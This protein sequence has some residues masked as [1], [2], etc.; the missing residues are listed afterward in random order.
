MR[1]AETG[2]KRLAVVMRNA[3]DESGAERGIE[4]LIVAGG[5]EQAEGRVVAK[6]VIYG[7]T[8]INAP[9]IFCIK[10]E[11]LNILRKA[12]IARGFGKRCHWRSR[13]GIARD[14]S[15]NRWDPEEK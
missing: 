15:D 7:E 9:G 1:D 11:A 12:A 6:P 3:V 14:Y 10:S 13:R 8:G 2:S 4:T 5:N